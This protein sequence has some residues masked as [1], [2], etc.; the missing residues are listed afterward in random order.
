MT[1]GGRQLPRLP[2]AQTVQ[3]EGHSLLL[4]L[5]WLLLQQLRVLLRT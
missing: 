3:Q 2:P 1:H 4:K 5:H